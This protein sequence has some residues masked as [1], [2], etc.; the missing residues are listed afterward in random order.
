MPTN[1]TT[2]FSLFERERE[3]ANP[4]V[5]A[6]TSNLVNIRKKNINPILKKVLTVR[7]YD[8]LRNPGELEVDELKTNWSLSGLY[9]TKVKAR[10][11]NKIKICGQ[12]AKLNHI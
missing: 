10:G 11:E 5:A 9:Y 8:I 3:Y 1:K 2:N 6:I 7:E 12:L 4:M